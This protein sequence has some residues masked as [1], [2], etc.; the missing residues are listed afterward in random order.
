MTIHNIELLMIMLVT[1]RINK[2]CALLLLF[3][4]F[5]FINIIP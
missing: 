3:Y 1:L 5:H 2:T 4:Y